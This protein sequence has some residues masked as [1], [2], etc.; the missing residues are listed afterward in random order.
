MS[1][2]NP[3]RYFHAKLVLNQWLL[4]RFGI[5]SLAEHRDAGRLVAPIEQLTKTFRSAGTGLSAN[6]QH[7]YLGALLAHWQPT[8]SYSE[9]QLQAFDDN[10]VAHTDAINRRRGEPIA[11]KY[12]QWASLLFA[13]IY[14]FEYFRNREAL[15]QSLNAHV[16]RFN[17]HWAG[18]GYQTGID[19]YQQADLNKLCLQNAT[20]SGK[21]LLMHVNVLQFRHYAHAYG[22]ADQYGQIILVSPN[23]RLSE[24]HRRE[25]SASDLA[26]ERLQPDGGDLLTG[27]QNNLSRIAVTEITKLHTDAGVQR[28]AVGSFGDNN[29]LLVDEGHRGLGAG[30]GKRK[31]EENGWLTHRDKLAGCGFTFEYSATFKEAVVAANDNVIEASYAR[32]ILFDYSYRYFYADGYGKDYRIF[33]LPND[34]ERHERHYLTA[35]LLTFYQQLRLSRDKASQ[36]REYN[37]ARPLWVFVGASV[38]RE[39]GKSRLSKQGVGSD[40]LGKDASSDVAKVIDFLAWFLAHPADATLALTKLLAGRGHDLGLVDGNNHNL[41]YGSFAYLE[42]LDQAAGTVFADICRLLFHSD[43][44]APLLIERIR[45]DSG[46][47]LL[48]LDGASEPFGLINVGDAALTWATRPAW[49][50][51]WTGVSRTT[52]TSSCES[53]NS[54]RRAS[55]KFG[56]TARPS[57]CCWV[58]E[59]S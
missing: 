35:A 20:G 47:L 11:W 21:T 28:M 16:E 15:R 1:Y 49:P 48:R 54:P 36:W 5:D 17:A 10:I 14:L 50:N 38:I 59:N 13:D 22:L 46:E 58:P 7:Q 55:P 37:L 25:L 3:K 41:F 26:N 32:N 9:T 29:L 45:G 39:D 19:P 6:R 27:A 42:G 31:R 57:T 2:L 44:P 8:W 52:N 43:A 53:P 33:N 24:Q 23:E 18:R 56:K 34:H 4:A 12:F 30:S 40:A 51:T